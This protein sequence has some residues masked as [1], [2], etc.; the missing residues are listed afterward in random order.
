MQQRAATGTQLATSPRVGQLW[1]ARLLRWS[2]QDKS[3]HA[4]ELFHHVAHAA[5]L[6]LCALGRRCISGRSN[7]LSG[8]GE[9]RFQACPFSL[10]QPDKQLVPVHV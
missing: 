5:R 3:L 7:A 4:L 2:L 10:G 6:G 1:S 8:A 9:V